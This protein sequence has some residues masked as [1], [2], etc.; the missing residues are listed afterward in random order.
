MHMKPVMQFR[1]S[2][3]WLF[4]LVS[5]NFAFAATSDWDACSGRLERALDA[6][7]RDSIKKNKLD[8]ED[9]GTMYQR[10]LRSAPLEM[11]VSRMA[12]KLLENTKEP[13][14]HWA[15]VEQCLYDPDR[16]SL[17][18]RVVFND[19]LV[20]GMVSLMPRDIHHASISAESC[21]MTL[22]LR[23]AGIDFLTSPIARGRGQ[24]RIRTE[25]SFLEPRFASIYAYGCRP[26]RID[27][28][29]KRQDKWPSYHLAN[30]NKVNIGKVSLSQT[31]KKKRHMHIAKKYV[32]CSPE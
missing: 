18:T 32:Y 24:M 20:S 30:I 2:T 28:Q 27:K 11:F 19:L 1:Q 17:S 15:R 4:K 29:I 22:R 6:L 16:N 12:V 7:H 26:T 5:I 31:D 25:S 3:I 21:R 10:E 9:V 13:G 8:E 23:R 14:G